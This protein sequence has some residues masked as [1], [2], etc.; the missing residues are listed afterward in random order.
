LYLN[1]TF[2][3]GNLYAGNLKDAFAESS[4]LREL[5]EVLGVGV[6]IEREVGLE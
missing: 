6:V 3:I 2:L 5:F 4:F 1:V